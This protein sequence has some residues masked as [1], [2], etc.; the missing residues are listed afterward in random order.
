MYKNC[1]LGL[2][3]EQ[4]YEWND[5]KGIWKSSLITIQNVSF[6]FLVFVQW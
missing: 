1:S 4:T 3:K 5:Q 2:P 6:T